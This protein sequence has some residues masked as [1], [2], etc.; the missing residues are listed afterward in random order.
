MKKLCSMLLALVLVFSLCT[1]AMAAEN[2]G[3]TVETK[4]VGLNTIS[5][6]ISADADGLKNSRIVF[7]WPEGLTLVSVE[8]KLP[9]DAGITDLDTS[10]AGSV[11]FAWA[12]YDTQKET[13]LLELVFTGANGESFEATLQTPENGGSQSVTLSVP[14]R[15]RDVMD[16]EAWYYD[17]VYAVYDM[18]LMEGVGS[19]LFAPQLTLSRATVVTVLYRLAGSPEVSG[20]NVFTDVADSAWYTDAV[21]WASE[22]GV[23]KGYGNGTFAPD[24]AVTRQELAA[25]FYRFRAYEGGDVTVDADALAAYNDADQVASWAKNAM[26]WAVSNGV[27]KGMPGKLLKPEDNAT[28][29]QMAQILL[30]NENAK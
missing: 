13:A 12:A 17:A 11:S 15:F 7:S 6:T 4:A 16:P 14:Y 2:G 8:S 19:N 25:M 3:F 24:K 1:T 5:V 21:K 10:K 22:S 27:L 18:G 28:R 30:N 9:A 29:A 26:S 23:V 20:E